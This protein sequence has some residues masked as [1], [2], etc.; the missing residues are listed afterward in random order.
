MSHRILLVEDEEG[1]RITLKDRL[2]G[3][4]YEIETAADGALGF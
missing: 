4:G 2:S 3:E 1:L